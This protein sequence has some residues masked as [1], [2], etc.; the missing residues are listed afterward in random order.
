MNIRYYSLVALVAVLATASGCAVHVRG[1]R[2]HAAP[3]PPPAAAAATPAPAASPATV[4]A[5]HA[6]PPPAKKVTHLGTRK[7]SFAADKDTVMV[8]AR[9]GLFKALQLRVSGSPMEMYNVRV[10]FGDG[11]AYSPNTRMNF[12]QGSW[13]RQIDL[14]G[15][16]RIIRKVEFWYRSKGPR[17]GRATVQV[18]GLS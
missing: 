2:R 10:V 1:P 3:P 15:G 4:Q 8:T 6:S 9:D 16:K 7:V 13:T 17:S 18:F 5:R 11:T 12:A 14:P